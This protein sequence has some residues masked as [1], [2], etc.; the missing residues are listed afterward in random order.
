[1]IDVY[2]ANPE[3]LANLIDNYVNDL[4]KIYQ[5]QKAFD[6]GYNNFSVNVLKDKYLDIL[7]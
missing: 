6:I 4:N 1:M 2:E 5:K 7:K 3:L